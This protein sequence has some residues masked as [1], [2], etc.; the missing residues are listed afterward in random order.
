[1]VENQTEGET[2]NLGHIRLNLKGQYAQL[3]VRGS[4]GSIGAKLTGAASK[5]ARQDP[6]DRSMPMQ[7]CSALALASHPNGR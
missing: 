2:F 7:G 4:L 3:I 1:M 5:Q 6:T